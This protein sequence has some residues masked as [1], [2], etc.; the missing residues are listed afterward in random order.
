MHKPIL[1][2]VLTAVACAAPAIAHDFWLQ[3]HDFRVDPGAV[4]PATLQVGHGPDRQRSPI[5]AERITA[6]RSIGPDGAVDQ[7]PGLHL[8]GPDEDARLRFDA[9]GTHVVAL[10]TN[11]TV[12][13]LP[14]LRFNDYLK[15]E[16]LTP[17]IA[18]RARTGT[19]DGPGREFYSRRAK[20]IVQVG[21][22]GPDPQPHVTE[23]VGLTLEIVPEANPYTLKPH[24]PLPVRVVYE[25]RPLAGALV[26]LTNLDADERPIEIRLTDAAGRAAFTLP[27]AGSWLLN[28]VWTKPIPADRTADYV[29]VFSSLS[30]GSPE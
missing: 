9:P 30:F 6:L 29:T 22:P 4:A 24:E 5:P 11:A 15:A 12:S 13:N 17:A 28:V 18:W 14:A 19:A 1:V 8:G 16:G 7:R 27:H 10:E 20:A 25:G 2:L 23:P 26:K 21:P 3:P